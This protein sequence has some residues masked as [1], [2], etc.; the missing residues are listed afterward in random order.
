MGGE[1]VVWGFFVCF[2]R[3]GLGDPEMGTTPLT[4]YANVSIKRFSYHSPGFTSGHVR[5][6]TCLAVLLESLK[7][8]V[9]ISLTPVI[10][11]LL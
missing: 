4:L 7:H 1:G 3:E 9:K 2:L 5:P 6:L 11:M 10:I 8:P